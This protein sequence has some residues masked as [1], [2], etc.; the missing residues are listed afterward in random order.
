[1]E[2]STPVYSE[3]MDVTAIINF[4]FLFIFREH[5]IWSLAGERETLGRFS[6]HQNLR[7]KRFT[8]S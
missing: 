8:E 2:G 6:K 3:K 5:T 7:W 4:W 1:M